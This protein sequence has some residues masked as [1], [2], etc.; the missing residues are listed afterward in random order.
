MIST[1]PVS[2]SDAV[3]RKPN[4][5]NNLNMYFML[6]RHISYHTK[7]TTFCIIC[8][9]ITVSYL[10]GKWAAGIKMIHHLFSRCTPIF[11]EISVR[12]RNRPHKLVN[13]FSPA[14][15]S[16]GTLYV[17]TSR[18]V[19]KIQCPFSWLRLIHCGFKWYSQ[20]FF[21]VIYRFLFSL[22][23]LSNFQTIIKICDWPSII[24]L[25]MS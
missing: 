11:Y 17:T 20:T 12:L 2:T 21:K 13:I 19:D 23:L 3:L 7:N 25:K 9:R 4:L 8:P 6:W 14:Q 24:I 1:E 16:I 18:H 10:L 15:T 5:Y 22:Y